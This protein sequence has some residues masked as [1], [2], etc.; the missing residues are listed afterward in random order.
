MKMRKKLIKKLNILN[1]TIHINYYNNYNLYNYYNN[2]NLKF[3]YLYETK[4]TNYR[5]YIKY[6]TFFFKSNVLRQ[7][8]IKSKF[9]LI[10]SF[11]Y[12]INQK[13]KF[14]KNEKKINFYR[15]K[16]YQFKE[17]INKYNY[18]IEKNS[19][20]LV[21]DINLFNII[22]LYKEIII[23]SFLLNLAKVYEYYKIIT[24]LMVKNLI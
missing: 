15:F 20:Y 21:T 4:R 14:Y 19:S 6:I 8:L 2:Y 24:I 9:N 5:K 23:I 16:N 10:K 18:K 7:Q 3:Y 11:M 1:Q 17:S 13:N 12:S 22:I